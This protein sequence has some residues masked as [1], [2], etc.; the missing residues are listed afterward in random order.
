MTCETADSLRPE[1]FADLAGL[2][3]DQQASYAGGWCGPSYAADEWLS[4]AVAY[5]GFAVPV[6]DW[7][8]E[9]G[10]EAEPVLE[11]LL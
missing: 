7:P 2:V 3:V 9:V 10:R 6:R 8:S 11:V 1:Q 5:P 4:S